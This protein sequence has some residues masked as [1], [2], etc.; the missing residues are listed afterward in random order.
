M[1]EQRPSKDVTTCKHEAEF[2]MLDTLPCPWC[3]IDELKRGREELQCCLNHYQA[4]FSLI[5][6]AW[7]SGDNSAVLDAVRKHITAKDCEDADRIARASHEPPAA[8][9]FL[10]FYEDHVVT[11]EVFTGEGAEYAARTRFKQ[12]RD[13]WS[14]HLFAKIDDSTRALQSLPAIAETAVGYRYIPAN[15]ATAVCDAAY[16]R[17]AATNEKAADALR[18]A[19]LAIIE[20]GIQVS[21]V[22]AAQ[23]PASEQDTDEYT[24]MNLSMF[25]RRLARL[26]RKHEPD[27]KAAAQA[28]E[29]IERKGLQG[30]PLRTSQPPGDVPG[31]LHTLE[32]LRQRWSHN[33]N[34]EATIGAC[35]TEIEL[36]VER[37]A[38]ATST[39]GANDADA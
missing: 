13:H 39:K 37:A 29:F 9:A 20:A 10:I 24:T 7:R 38:R 21:G 2:R 1:N 27:S 33:A 8:P 12:A 16:K 26:L 35:I 17:A 5:T 36:C 19:M 22:R 25:V 11:P 3:V 15:I 6:N 32:V 30:S 34:F 18:P 28:L 31:L 4:R 23:P 14:C